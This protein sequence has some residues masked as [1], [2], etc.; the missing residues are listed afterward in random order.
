MKQGSSAD[1][2]QMTSYLLA[3]QDTWTSGH[4]RKTVGDHCPQ[5][6]PAASDTQDMLNKQL[7]RKT[8]VTEAPDKSNWC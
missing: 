3:L 8:C 2:V 1:A 5:G 4:R 7:L 6:V